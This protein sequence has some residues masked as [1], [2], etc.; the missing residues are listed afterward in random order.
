MFC[1]IE[2]LIIDLLTICFT[3]IKNFNLILIIVLKFFIILAKKKV[4]KIKFYN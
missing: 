4:L 1:I 3:K 2:G